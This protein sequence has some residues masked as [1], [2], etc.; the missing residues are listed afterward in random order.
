MYKIVIPS[1]KREKIIKQ[2]TLT[3]LDKH[4]INKKDIYIFVEESEIENYKNELLSDSNQ[5]NIVAG[6]KGIG[7]QRTAISNYFEDNQVIV[8]L[9]DDVEE[10]LDNGLPLANLHYFIKDTINFLHAHH[11]TLAGIY[12]VNNNYF[13]KNTITIDNR[14][15]IGQFKIFINKKHLENRSYELLEDY[16]NTLKHAIWSGGVMR[17]NY[18]T[19]KANYN[20]GKGGLKEY[21]TLERKLD[22]VKRFSLEYKNYC[23]TKKN[24]MEISILK[25][26]IRKELTTLWIGK[27]FNKLSKLSVVSWLRLGYKVNLYINQNFRLPLDMKHWEINGQLIFHNANDILDTKKIKDIL[28]F[29][30]L[31]RYTYLYNHHG[32][33]WIDADM[34]LLKQLPDDEI[35]ISS[36]HTFQ[37][38]AYKSKE[39]KICNIG[40]LRMPLGCPILK[41]IIDKI[42][43]TG[44][45][46]TEF[47]DNMKTFRTIINK[48][49]Y[50]KFITD[51]NFIVEPEVYC[52][53]PWWNCKEMYYD[54]KYK[55]KYDVDVKSNDWIL[56]NS[57]GIHLW[58]NFTFNKH[59]I[60]FS[61]IKNDSI[62][63]RLFHHYL[64]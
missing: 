38:G 2:K 39:S 37:S 18:I 62:Y 29:S 50:K 6:A 40:V 25:N 43:K 27:E 7:K 1:Y 9:D 12:P 17:Y 23:G 15:L 33:T 30:D 48:S 41:S 13:T 35:I 52:P 36:E 55:T 58:N 22:E 60:D 44:L 61:N 26:P 8:S 63:H 4:N 45:K 34:I 42:N 32:K 24:G 49:Y 54:T 14:F 53:I 57:I 11:L 56:A 19:L 28:P 31:W 5:Y 21:R 10:I 59:E 64:N 20:S 46:N 47:C 3:L 16:E 51:Q